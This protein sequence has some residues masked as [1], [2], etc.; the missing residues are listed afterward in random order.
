MPRAAGAADRAQEYADDPAKA[1]GDAADAASRAV[2]AAAG[3]AQ[4]AVRAGE[5]A[6]DDGDVDRAAQRLEGG[7]SDAARQTQGGIQ[8]AAGALQAAVEDPYGTAEG[9]IQQVLTL[10]ATKSRVARCLLCGCAMDMACS[11]DGVHVRTQ[12]DQAQGRRA[13]SCCFRCAQV[14]GAA[15]RSTAQ[16]RQALEQARE[17]LQSAGP[18]APYAATPLT[19]L[20][21]T[22]G[23]G[24]DQAR[25]ALG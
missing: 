16:A 13:R 24:V 15:E 6:V 1:V 8:D 21:V 7:I 10:S 20:P 9:V 4:R 25:C 19:S 12:G 18:S 11:A 3:G 2:G 22:P 23:E 17:E 5:D 14:T